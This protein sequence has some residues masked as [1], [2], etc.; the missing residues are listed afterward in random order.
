MKLQTIH[1]PFSFL[2]D[3]FSGNAEGKVSK[4]SALRVPPIRGHVRMWHQFAFGL[5]SCNRVW[6]STAGAG[7]GSR[8]SIALK[9]G[10]GFSAKTSE[11]LPHSE[12]PKK[13]G[14]RPCISAGQEA[15]I[16]LIRLP[17]CSPD[18]W[19]KAQKAVRLWLLLGSLGLRSN[20]AAGS[21]WPA[22]PPRTP[23]DF[24]QAINDLGLAQLQIAL[25]GLGKNRN[26]HELRETASDTVSQE[27]IFGTTRPRTPSPT[28]F[29]VVD[30]EEGTC[31]VA[32]APEKRRDFIKQAESA[33]MQ[34]TRWQTLG[35]W[36]Y[37]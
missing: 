10:G 13:R 23:N 37:I 36:N 32:I 17:L 16:D 34:N 1:Y 31:L 5:D 7:S 14:N 21:V 27:H 33:L 2:T 29:K 19:D 8:V 35:A 6:G 15:S 26:A 28:K 11:I 22:D 30:F 20:R 18:D 24:R 4:H 9:S 12:D 25:V 3:C